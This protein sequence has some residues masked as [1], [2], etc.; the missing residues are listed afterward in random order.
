MKSER[1]RPSASAARSISAFCF[2]LAR[3]LMVSSRLLLALVLLMFLVAGIYSSC[4]H[5]EYTFLGLFCKRSF[6]LRHCLG[7]P[8]LLGSNI[9]CEARLLAGLSAGNPSA[10]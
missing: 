1:L 9:L 4:I 2:R 7:L 8:S 5:N 10:M 3:R 6:P